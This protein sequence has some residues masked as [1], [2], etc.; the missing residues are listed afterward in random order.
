MS[1][2]E[3]IIQVSGLDKSYG[4]RHV[5]NDLNFE[6][7]AG[8]I[9]GLLGP[10]GAGKTTTLSILAT[11]RKPDKGV[12]RIAGYD[13][14]D[15]PA[16][17]RHRIGFVPQSIALYPS[18]TASHNVEL[19]ARVHGLSARQAREASD[20]ALDKVG[21]ND[22]KGD[23]IA[24]LSGGMQRRV[25]LACGMVHHPEILLLDEPTVGVDPQS[26]ERILETLRALAA[27]GATIVYSTHYMEEVERLCDCALLI[28]HGHLI[29]RGTVAEL[30]ALGGSHHRM[31]ITFRE[32]PSADL[33]AGLEGVSEIDSTPAADHITLGLA[34][35]ARVG[36]V[37]DRASRAG[38]PVLEFNLH[39][40][41]LSDAF[42]SLTGH[43]LRD[44]NS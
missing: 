9:A 14:L 32:P 20:D 40:P 25:N 38:F 4:S 31:E 16:A 13:A 43:A 12:V 36:P 18:L 10:N 39:S 21:L 44:T 35:L 8:E 5:L 2:A 28:D 26:R 33:F 11:L 41:N 42:M 37:L 34:G 1:N 7:K 30:V 19:F 15:D 27:A 22:R 29:A 23:A 6:V 17:V 3:T 24:S